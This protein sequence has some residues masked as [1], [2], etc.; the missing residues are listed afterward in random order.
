MPL[1]VKVGS[2]AMSLRTQHD[3]AE[4]PPTPSAP[5]L[6]RPLEARDLWGTEPIGFHGSPP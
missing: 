6:G 4:P 1:A 5:S 2:G 3:L